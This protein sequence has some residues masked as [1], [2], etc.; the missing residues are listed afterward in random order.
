MMHPMQLSTEQKPAFFHKTLCRIGGG[1]PEQ[2][3]GINAPGVALE[4]STDPKPNPQ[5][6]KAE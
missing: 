3:D 6:E 5:V 4:E 1:R 2:G